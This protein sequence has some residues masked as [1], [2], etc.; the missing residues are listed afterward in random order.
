MK[1]PGVPVCSQS[2]LLPPLMLL[3]HHGLCTFAS[4]WSSCSS[5]TMVFMLLPP[6]VDF[7]LCLDIINLTFS[8]FGLNHKDWLFYLLFVP[9]GNVVKWDGL[10]L[11]PWSV[12]FSSVIQLCP[13]LC[14]PMDC[15]MPGLPVHHWLLE[16]TQTD[17]LRVSDA[18][19]QSHLL[20]S[21]SPPA[22]NLSQHW[23]LFQWVS[24]LHQGVK[25]L[26]FQLQHQSFQWIFWTDFL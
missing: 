12:Q 10:A 23:G 7:S 26:E 20:S 4:L 18:I 24:S 13:T 6:T 8:I 14:D 16:L 5:T 15:S 1:I 17:V 3:L 11:W 19:Q 2:K 9:G 22:F 25:V 21:S